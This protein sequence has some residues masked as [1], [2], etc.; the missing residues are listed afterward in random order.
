MTNENFSNAFDTLLSSYQHSSEFGKQSSIADINIDEYEKSIF[1]TQA[2]DQIVKSYFDRSLSPNGEGFD[3]STRRQLDFSNLITTKSIS[4]NSTLKGNGYSDEGIIVPFKDSDFMQ[5]GSK[6]SP[7]FIINERVKTADSSYVVVPINY[8][9][10]DRMMSKAYCEPL[11]RQ[12]WRLFGTN[13]SDLSR[14]I[15]LILR[16]DASAPIKYIVRYV[17]KPRPI[18]LVNLNDTVNN[19]EIDGVSEETTCELNPIIHNDILTLAVQLVLASKGIET[20][21]IKAL[22]EQNN[23]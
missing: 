15:E 22:K 21:D 12:A 1:L 19:L 20:R 7:L 4:I 2:Q 18:V 9:E 8:K 14:Q 23:R 10:Y 17:R 6:S 3:D 13:N 5:D 11:K 16:S